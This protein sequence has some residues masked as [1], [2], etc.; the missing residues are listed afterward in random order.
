MG[1]LFLFAWEQDQ[2]KTAANTIASWGWQVQL[3]WQDGGRGSAAVKAA[4]PDVLVFY[5][6]HKP[7]HSRAT[8]EHLANTK[9]TRYIPMVFVGGAGEGLQK[10]RNLF[11]TGFFI[12]EDELQHTLEGL[13]PK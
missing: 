3:E 1:R 4:L 10:A 7:S 2:A 9:S 8:A 12:A 6:D 13:R 11:P 5:L